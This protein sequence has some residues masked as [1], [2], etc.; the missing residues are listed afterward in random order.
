[1]FILTRNQMARLAAYSR[2]QFT[3]KACRILRDRQPA[4]AAL[5]IAE[6]QRL[7]ERGFEKATRYQFVDED[8]VLDLLELFVLHG[9]DMDEDPQRPWLGE[10][11]GVTVNPPR[12]RLR[13]LHWI[14][15][16]KAE[17]VSPA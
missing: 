16:H 14:I 10:I 17:A 5:D 8:E 1:M 4:A 12:L 6:L 2:Q 3:D 13:Q 7:V 15:R 11:L 9:V